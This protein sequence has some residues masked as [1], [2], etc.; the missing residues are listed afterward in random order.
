ML[1][2]DDLV[3]EL[4]M[5]VLKFESGRDILALRCSGKEWKEATE[6]FKKLDWKAEVIIGKGPVMTLVI[7]S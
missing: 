5:V 7:E 3:N 6:E 4:K 2:L 1:S